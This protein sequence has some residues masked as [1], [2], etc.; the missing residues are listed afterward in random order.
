MGAAMV[1]ASGVANQASVFFKYAAAPPPAASSGVENMNDTASSR[2]RER[3]ML[4]GGLLVGLEDDVL[5][6]DGHRL[7]GVELEAE[8]TGFRADGGVVGDVDGLLAVDEVLEMAALGDDD[9]LVPVGGLDGGL[10]FIGLADL[11]GDFDL[12]LLGVGAIGDDDLL[13]ALGED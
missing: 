4:K 8:D 13:A 2:R 1:F 10:D 11:T 7:A 3:G 5:V 12:G 9:V 6:L